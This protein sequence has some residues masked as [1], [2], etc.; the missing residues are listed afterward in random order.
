MVFFFEMVTDAFAPAFVQAAPTFAVAP[1]VVA[2]DDDPEPIFN[3]PRRSWYD[4]V[5]RDS[6]EL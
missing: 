3:V 1:A 4:W 6:A 5:I 2:E